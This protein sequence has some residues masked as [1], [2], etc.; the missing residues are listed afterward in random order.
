VENDYVE[1]KF[2]ETQA[3]DDNEISIT[4]FLQH[5]QVREQE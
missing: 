4:K 2:L 5:E 3:A 1:V